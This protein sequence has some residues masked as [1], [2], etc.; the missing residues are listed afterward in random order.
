M[1]QA[2]TV[3]SSPPT[4]NHHTINC[5]DPLTQVPKRLRGKVGHLL[6]QAPEPQQRPRQR[7]FVFVLGGY[8]YVCIR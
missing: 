1:S 6:H 5:K 7:A 2:M 4:S 3:L 8:V